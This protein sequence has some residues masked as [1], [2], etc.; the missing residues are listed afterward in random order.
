MKHLLSFILTSTM[1][2][3]L[4]SCSEGSKQVLHQIPQGTN[5]KDC[6][7]VFSNE[8]DH[9]MFVEEETEGEAVV[10]DG[11]KG[12]TYPAI[13]VASLSTDGIHFAYIALS[14]KNEVVVKDG[15]E[16]ASYA[17]KTII[18]RDNISKT[19]QFVSDGS[20]IYTKRESK[21]MKKIMKDGK[22]L[23]KTPYSAKPEVS[24]NG[25]HL[26]YWI[27]DGTGDFLVFDGKKYSIEGIPLFLSLSGNGEHYGAVIANQGKTTVLI[28][29]KEATTIESENPIT[30][31][32]LS[33]T[34]KHF[35]VLQEDPSVNQIKIKFDGAVVSVA[36]KVFTNSITFSD[37]DIHYALTAMKRNINK[38][39]IVID[40]KEVQCYDAN[41]FGINECFN[42]GRKLQFSPDGEKILYVAGTGTNQIVALNQKII[43]RLNLYNTEIFTVFF[44]SKN[45]INCLFL[46]KIKNQVVKSTKAIL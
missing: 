30:F 44:S 16:I 26:L 31:F 6:S 46:D 34:G 5:I 13:D 23:D 43:M 36:E 18:R 41:F 45:E 29:G 9:F 12:K 20:L 27:V 33:N 22:V 10:Y 28:D 17:Y 7:M 40:G 38:A 14:G 15:K 42:E 2:F 11:Q 1:L 21:K 39:I 8:A 3:P 4:F 37:D 35:I 24:D 32:L 19:L 25:N